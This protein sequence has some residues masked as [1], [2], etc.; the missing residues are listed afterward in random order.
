LGTTAPTEQNQQKVTTPAE[1]AAD[2]KPALSVTQ[3]ADARLENSAVHNKNTH[4][5][6]QKRA[7]RPNSSNDNVKGRRQVAELPSDRNVA[8]ADR[9]APVAVSKQRDNFTVDFVTASQPPQQR[10]PAADVGQPNSDFDV[11]LSEPSSLC[12]GQHQSSTHIKAEEFLKVS[13]SQFL[14]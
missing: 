13:S 14:S 11:R 2:I 6:Q 3:P 4:S 1:T 9:D 12:E 10:V 8:K 5:Q 7:P